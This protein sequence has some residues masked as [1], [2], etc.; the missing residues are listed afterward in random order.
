MV[1]DEYREAL[2]RIKRRKER[3]TG[4]GQRK[5]TKGWKKGAEDRGSMKKG[6]GRGL[7]TKKGKEEME[8][9]GL[10]SSVVE[11]DGGGAL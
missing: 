6:G 1:G 7:N 2:G 8:E 4:I 10:S 3:S 5:D 11:G 9:G